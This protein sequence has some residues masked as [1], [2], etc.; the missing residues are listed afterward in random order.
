MEFNEK[1]TAAWFIG[2][3]EGDGNFAYNGGSPGRG[4][5]HPILQIHQM[6]RDVLD[7]TVAWLQKQGISCNVAI[8]NGRG[9]KGRIQVACLTIRSQRSMVIVIPW[10]RK[11]LVSSKRQKQFQ[12]WSEKHSEYLTEAGV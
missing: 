12:A 11:H 2:F 6:E 5:K 4:R 3:F 8:R 10:L 9:F 1:I 7:K